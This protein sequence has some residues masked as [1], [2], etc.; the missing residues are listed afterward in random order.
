MRDALGQEL[1][2]GDFIT[3]PGRSGSNM[4]INFG[5]I[6]EL[7]NNKLKVY[8]TGEKYYFKGS[9]TIRRIAVVSCID[10]VIKIDPAI[11]HD[12]ELKAKIAFLTK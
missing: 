5:I 12:D 4:W 11:V 9:K 3:Y 6:K 7:V 2:V 8:I 10:R 1:V